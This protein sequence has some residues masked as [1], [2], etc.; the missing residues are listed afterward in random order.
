MTEAY[1]VPEPE[2]A[3]L[4]QAV[5]SSGLPPLHTL[6]PQEARQ[7][8]SNRVRA[9]NLVAEP[10]EDVQDIFIRGRDAGKL[11]L[12]VYRPG[13]GVRRP[14]LI[15][16]HGGGFVIGSIETHDPV[17]RY[18][19]AKAGWTVL[20]VDYRLAPEH[21]YPAAVHDALDTLDWVWA[22]ADALRVD[23]GRVAVAGD[24]AGGTLAAVVAQHASRQ[25][26]RLAHQILL[27]PALDQGGNYDSRAVFRDKFL[28]TR[29]SIEW[30]ARQYY[31]HGHPE[32]SPC[33][34]PARAADLEGLA[35]AWIVTAELDPLRDEA[36]HYA[37]LLEA[38]GVKTRYRCL[39]GTLHGFLGMARYVS[40]ARRE[41][42]ELAGFLRSDLAG[43][44]MPS[45]ASQL[46]G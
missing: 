22:N 11:R 32:L 33:A 21:R 4:L 42:D 15:Y 23:L 41:L 39:Q 26:R 40:A 3:A 37:A 8:F 38:A 12:R 35:P 17:C 2:T 31:G 36:A 25:G 24:S 43:G 45:P 27:Y 19:A 5:A 6:S 10:V 13:G 29:E 18:V 46:Q 20:S 30:F 16:F 44:D 14:L 34:S 9:T 28:L 7:A 1:G